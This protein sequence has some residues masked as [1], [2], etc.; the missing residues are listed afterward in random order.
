MKKI[1]IKETPI[2][3]GIPQYDKTIEKV[4]ITNNPTEDMVHHINMTSQMCE[5]T[6]VAWLPYAYCMEYTGLSYDEPLIE[7]VCDKKHV[8]VEGIHY[9]LEVLEESV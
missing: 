3:W 2:L 7:G 9:E 8:V 1:K 4:V 5:V 6:N